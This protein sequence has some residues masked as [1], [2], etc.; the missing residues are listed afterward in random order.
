MG[1][2]KISEFHQLDPLLS[3]LYSLKLYSLYKVMME[4]TVELFSEGCGVEEL[5]VNIKH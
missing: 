3:A 2:I 5:D 1:F 4:I